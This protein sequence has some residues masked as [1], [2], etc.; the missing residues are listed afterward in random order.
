MSG[1]VILNIIVNGEKKG[2]KLVTFIIELSGV[3]V[4]N[5]IKYIGIN[6]SMFKGITAWLIFSKFVVIDP[7]IIARIIKVIRPTNTNMILNINTQIICPLIC[8]NT[9]QGFRK[10]NVFS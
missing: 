7:I 8:Y 1:V 10:I 5:M 4:L 9:P 6:N 3:S 2:I